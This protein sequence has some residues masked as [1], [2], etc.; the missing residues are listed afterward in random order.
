TSVSVQLAA[1]I[2]RASGHATLLVDADMRAPDIHRLLG[3]EKS[4]G[5]ADVLAQQATLDEAINTNWSSSVHVLAAGRRGVSPYSLLGNGNLEPLLRELAER[6]AYVV[7]D[8]PP[9]LACAESMILAKAADVT[10]ICA[11]R[12]VSRMDQVHKAT[13]R[14]GVTGARLAGLVLVGVPSRIYSYRY[15]RYRFQE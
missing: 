11:R 8:T 2:A 1:S 10:L 4:P 9:V 14:L 6:Y 5:L 13:E 3:V 15:G 7:I 12:D